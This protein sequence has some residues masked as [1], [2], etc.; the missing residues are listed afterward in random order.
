MAG[1]LKM[2]LRAFTFRGGSVPQ[3]DNFFK[4]PLCLKKL[5][6]RNF[7]KSQKLEQNN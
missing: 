3:S 4:K 7:Q 2:G 5:I 1:L 6:F